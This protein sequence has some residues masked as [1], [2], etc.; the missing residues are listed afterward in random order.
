VTVNDAAGASVRANFA[1]DTQTATLTLA[2][3][4][5]GTGT[6]SPAVGNH[7]VNV[8]AATAIAATPAAGKAFTSWTLVSGNA[9]IVNAGSASTTVTVNDAAGASVRANFAADIPAP[10]A[11][12]VA[13]PA[14]GMAPLSV[15]LDAGGSSGDLTH[16][17][18]DY[19]YDGS[20]LAD[21]DTG[22]AP[23]AS[24]VYTTAG[25]HVAAVRV[26]DAFGRSD[27]ATANIVVSSSFGAELTASIVASVKQ[28]MIPLEVTFDASRSVGAIC[29][30]E[31]DF[32]YDGIVFSPD[33]EAGHAVNASHTFSLPGIYRVAVR[34]SD[35]I[36][37]HAVSSIWISAFGGPP[38]TVSLSAEPPAGHA[39]LET[40]ITATATGSIVSYEWDWDYDGLDFQADAATGTVNHATTTYPVAKAH[41]AAVRVTDAH[42]SVVIAALPIAV[43]GNGTRNPFVRFGANTYDRAIGSVST[44]GGGTRLD[45]Y[46]TWGDAIVFEDMDFAHGAR[47]CTMSYLAGD[48]DGEVFELWIDGLPDGGGTLVGSVAAHA[49]GSSQGAM[50]VQGRHDL[51]LLV[52]TPGKWLRVVDL[53]F[54]P[55]T[56]AGIPPTA[57]IH[58]SAK[59]GMAPLAVDFSAAESYAPAGSSIRTFEWDL[60]LDGEGFHADIDTGASPYLLGETFTEGTTTVAVRVTE[61]LGGS[62]IAAVTLNVVD[63]TA[64]IIPAARRVDWRRTGVEGGIPDDLPILRTLTAGELAGNAG[65]PIQA[66]IDAAIAPGVIVLPAGTFNSSTPVYLKS[67]IVLRGQ[68][69]NLTRINVDCRNLIQAYAFQLRG[70]AA[71]T[72]IGIVAGALAGSCELTLTSTS[73]LRA[74]DVIDIYQDNDA[75][76]M[77]TDKEHGDGWDPGV[78]IIGQVV[79]LV[80]VEGNCV[81]IHRPLRFDFNPAFSPRCQKVNPIRRAGIENLRL[82]HADNDI[83]DYTLHIKYAENCWVRGVEFSMAAMADL[84]LE[85]SLLS[86]IEA[87]Y[88][89]GVWHMEPDYDGTAWYGGYSVL[90][91]RRAS[92]I[93]VTNNVAARGGT[94][95]MFKEGANGCVIAYNYGGEREYYS[96]TPNGDWSLATNDLCAHGHYPYAVLAE[97]NAFDTA[98]ASDYWGPGGPFITLFRNRLLG[99]RAIRILDRTHQVNLVGNVVPLDPDD[100]G[101]FY[102]REYDPV[103]IEADCLDPMVE[104]NLVLGVR[105]WHDL[106][107]QEMEPSLAFPDGPP[108]FWGNRP[109]PL[110]GADVDAAHAYPNYPKIPAEDWW[111]AISANG[112]TGIPFQS[113]AGGSP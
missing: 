33:P 87:N 50:D 13:S 89:H 67:G 22:A 49:S 81:R 55:S 20:F 85:N 62:A 57:K 106:S 113:I 112:G 16:Y 72:E 77:A 60:S 53:V 90:L 66:A 30:H 34:V 43:L 82:H 107:P 27:I 26:T 84:W 24:H 63:D 47:L 46:P 40:I 39:P 48:V 45:S 79:R 5:S 68:G 93:L 41:N 108:H 75:A 101:I 94:G 19:A 71:P 15:T 103:D 25:T 11:A 64:S 95:F 29:L 18:W 3:S 1:D 59:G 80:N 91:G 42:G 36:G 97:G 12:L 100:S 56:T 69:M 4:P 6:T 9:T 99:Y 111:Q 109:W 2:V 96:N 21:A 44:Y 8:G 10:V 92:D 104:G 70:S 83:H 51:Y 102:D 28:G 65:A 73:G 110:I 7:T 58:P 54:A 14:S 76:L 37:N 35:G 98:T 74:G 31:W 32:D 88:F 23:L 17:E 86:T 78:P 38:P 105:E 61:A 52:A